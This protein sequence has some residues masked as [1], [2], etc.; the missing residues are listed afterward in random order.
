MLK[1]AHVFRTFLL[2]ASAVLNAGRGTAG[3]IVYGNF[4]ANLDTG[5]LAGV[6]FPVTYSYDASQNNPVGESFNI[7]NS[8]D[9]TLLGTEFTRSDIDQ[10]GQVIL[11]D[12]VLDNITASFQGVLPPGAP[13]RNIT[14]GFGGPGV[15][16]Y[17]DLAGNYG[18]GTF[19]LNPVPEPGTLI[20]A[21]VA[22]GF[23]RLRP[24][25][26]L[27]HRLS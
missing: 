26:L 13:V 1:S 12:G 8:F 4:E 10:G 11:I 23:L 17:I 24:D 20:L 9:F 6:V 22:L 25:S 16:G 14:F 7:L 2:A 3:T 21:I 19:T 18:G 27:R 15:I 5:S